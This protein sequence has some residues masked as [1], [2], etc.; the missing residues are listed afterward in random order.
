L[1]E[2]ISKPDDT[3]VKNYAKKFFL[4]YNSLFDA[5]DNNMVPSI[6]QRIN[7]SF[8]FKNTSAFNCLLN[9]RN[10]IPVYKHDQIALIKNG[11]NVINSGGTIQMKNDFVKK[12][13]LTGTAKEYKQT[14]ERKYLWDLFKETD[15]IRNVDC[16][17]AYNIG[18][19]TT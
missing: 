3:A 10:T 15:L 19:Q 5:P 7:G 18:G 9:L 2:I 17:E 8:T 12:I 16:G 4:K 11:Y 13:S 1:E 6:S 14:V